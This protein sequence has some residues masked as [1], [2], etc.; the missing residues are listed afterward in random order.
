MIDDFLFID[1]T[2]D[3]C[4]AARGD[5]SWTEYRCDLML[6]IS[7]ERVLEPARAKNS[8]VK[9]IIKYP[10]SY[11]RERRKG[12]SMPEQRRRTF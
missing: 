8:N 7:R 9:L 11:S 1:C 2:C 4:Q 6:Q 5:K 10:L 3:E 12:M